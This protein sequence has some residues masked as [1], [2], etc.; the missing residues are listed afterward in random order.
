MVEFLNNNQNFSH[1]NVTLKQIFQPR[2]NKTFS[3]QNVFGL[4][5]EKD[6]ETRSK[7]FSVLV[8]ERAK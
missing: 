6:E 1:Q 2:K 7:E 4:E 3:K 5:G 8:H